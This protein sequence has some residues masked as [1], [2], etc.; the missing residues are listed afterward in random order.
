MSVA[1][2]S[3]TPVP[4]GEDVWGSHARV[5]VYDCQGASTYSAGYTIT[6][7]TFGLQVIRGI[8]L[9]A[10][11]T[12]DRFIT[13]VTT[14]AFGISGGTVRVYSDAGEVSGDDSAAYYHLRIEG[15]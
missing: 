15:E 3:L 1:F 14:A 5:R 13:Y 6:P 11:N 9:I 10:S 4:D 2:K 7:A 12:A 8:T